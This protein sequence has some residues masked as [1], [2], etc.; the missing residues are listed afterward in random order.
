MQEKALPSARGSILWIARTAVFIALLVSWQAITRPLSTLVTG[1]GV[2]M[3]LAVAVMT[4]GLWSGVAVGTI[5]PVMA[6]LFAIAPNPILVPF[7]A[8]SNIVYVTIW[9]F[10]GN[11]GK[12]NKYIAYV[13]AGITAAVGKFLVLFAGVAHFAIPV[14]ISPPEPQATVMAGMFSVPQLITASIG[15]ALA[16]IIFPTLKKAIK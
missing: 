8:V 10:I 4:C 15:G 1:S 14:L 13:I 11:I 2:N 3:I 5:S 6:W 7:I 9:H 12:I 16:I